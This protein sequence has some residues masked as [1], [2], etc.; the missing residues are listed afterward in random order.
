M[1]SRPAAPADPFAAAREQLA[2]V[3]LPA[4]R[5][6]IEDL[7]RTFGDQYPKGETYLARL[8]ELQGRLPAIRQALADG[9]AAAIEEAA[10]VER[11]QREALLTNPLLDFDKLLVV[12]RKPRDDARRPKGEGYGLGEFLGLPRQSS[13]QQDEIPDVDRWTNEIAVVSP[14]REAGDLKTAYRPPTTRLV[15][16]IDLD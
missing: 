12:L 3:D 1:A 2:R 9:Q 10:A 14:L 15:G 13:W 7:R 16:D 4:L 6:A 5:L 8:T 11:F